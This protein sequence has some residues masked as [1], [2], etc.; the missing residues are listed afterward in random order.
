MMHNPTDFERAQGRAD[1]A[2]DPRPCS[3]SELGYCDIHDAPWALAE[4][5][6]DLADGD[7]DPDVLVQEEMLRNGQSVLGPR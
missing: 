1:E 5:R 6:C 4:D 2:T 3:A 7:L